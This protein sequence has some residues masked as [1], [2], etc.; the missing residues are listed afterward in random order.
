MAVLSG[1]Y[2]HYSLYSNFELLFIVIITK[3]IIINDNAD[4]E[5]IEIN[6]KID[7]TDNRD[8][9]NNNK[10]DNINGDDNNDNDNKKNDKNNII[11]MINIYI[12]IILTSIHFYY[13]YHYYY[14]FVKFQNVAFD[15]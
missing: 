7:S 14:H 5:K 11:V 10:N 15:P 1:P 12:F 2:G 3:V 6:N 4:Y 8:D 9:G 13:F